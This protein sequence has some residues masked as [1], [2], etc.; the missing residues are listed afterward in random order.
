ML[1]PELHDTKNLIFGD[2]YNNI[3]RFLEKNNIDYINLGKLFENQKKE[4][5]LWVSYDDAHPNKIADKRIAEALIDFISKG[6]NNNDQKIHI[7]V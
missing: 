1:L 2:S 7:K 3:S 5:E 6:T 4:M